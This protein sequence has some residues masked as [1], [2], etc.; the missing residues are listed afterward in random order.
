VE[1]NWVILVDNPTCASV[2]PHML[3]P[4]VLQ[5]CCCSHFLLMRIQIFSF[6]LSQDSAS[7]KTGALSRTFIITSG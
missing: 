7:C 1:G 6:L 5:F 4:R 3:S 2:S